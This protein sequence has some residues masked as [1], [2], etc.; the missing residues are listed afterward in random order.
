[1]KLSGGELRGKPS[2]A[3]PISMLLPDPTL[4]VG[5]VALGV[6]LMQLYS[7]SIKKKKKN[8]IMYPRVK[9]VVIHIFTVHM[10]LLIYAVFQTVFIV[11]NWFIRSEQGK[12]KFLVEGEIFF[13]LA[14]QYQSYSV[15]L[16]INLIQIEF[17]T[18][19]NY[20]WVHMS[21]SWLNS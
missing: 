18:D 15:V 7:I 19:G 9:L 3:K 6:S 1:M 16:S 2:S 20:F 4:H 12:T 5:Y 13:L 10:Q 21:L 17:H 14:R 8:N 11:V